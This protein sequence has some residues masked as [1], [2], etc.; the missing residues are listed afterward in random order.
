MTGAKKLNILAINWQDWKAPQKGG[1]E[2]YLKEILLRLREYG[3]NITLLCSGYPGA[4]HTDQVDGIRV[5]RTGSRNTFNFHLYGRPIRS[6]LRNNS[7]DVIIDD[8]NK[9]PF[10]TPL[11]AGSTPV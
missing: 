9:I 10:Y 11:W 3:H 4:S 5:I 2:F 7:F 1:A 6:Y 8:L